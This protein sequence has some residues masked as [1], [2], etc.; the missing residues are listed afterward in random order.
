MFQASIRL[1]SISATA[2]ASACCADA[3]GKLAAALRREF[4]RI[5]EAHDAAPG[6]QNYRRGNHRPEQRAAA[7]F[8]QS[9]DALPSVLARLA[10]V[11]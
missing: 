9:S 6:V 3:H 10:L 8:V 2:H 11:T 7:C 5:V 1:A 4:L